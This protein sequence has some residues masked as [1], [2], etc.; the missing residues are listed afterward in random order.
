[1]PGS[2]QRDELLRRSALSLETAAVQP[3]EAI[4]HARA[5]LPA[6]HNDLIDAWVFANLWRRPAATF[7][8]ATQA[9]SVLDMHR[10]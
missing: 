8:P 1:M 4:I 9:G 10:A 2:D 6:R 5:L 7:V 3:P